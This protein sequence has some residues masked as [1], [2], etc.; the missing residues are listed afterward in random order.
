MSRI[1][2]Y[3]AFILSSIILLPLSTWILL[4]SN[5]YDIA[6]RQTP[7]WYA[8]LLLMAS[9]IRHIWLSDKVLAYIVGYI[10]ARACTNVYPSSLEVALMCVLGAYF[11][12]CCKY[13]SRKQ[14]TITFIVI[15]ATQVVYTSL[16]Y[17][18]FDPIWAG[19]TQRPMR[20]VGTL[21]H[22]NHVGELLAITSAL[23]PTLS[24]PFWFMTLCTLKSLTGTLAMGSALMMRAG[25]HIKWLFV[26][27]AILATYWWNVK[28]P[29]SLSD[30]ILVW[31]SAV[32]DQE[33]W[34]LLFGHG[35][36]SWFYRIPYLHPV[37]GGSGIGADVRY[38]EAHNDPLQLW[39]EAGSVAIM[40]IG[41]WLWQHRVL[42][43]NERGALVVAVGIVSLAGY[44]FHSAVT[45]ML[46]AVALG[47]AIYV[48]EE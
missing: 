15:G 2:Y 22:K 45:G 46:C 36:G 24:L 5:N 29:L 19:F 9:V 40:L 25:L 41:L 10:L 35:L 32:Q 23:A 26:P 42:I 30:R 17:Y 6:A 7:Y 37:T 3:A 13:I 18:G 38:F 20:I 47:T 28:A 1:N 31:R 21:G 12:V 4:T 33:W 43:N 34:T 11:M 44:P 39:Y 14:V 48:K 8:S 27:W 16:Q